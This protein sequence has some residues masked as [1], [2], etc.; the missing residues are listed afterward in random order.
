MSLPPYY[1]STFVSN[2]GWTF[3]ESTNP[4]DLANIASIPA[5]YI[6]INDQGNSV[7]FHNS[8]TSI[9]ESID[10]IQGFVPD[11]SRTYLCRI[12]MRKTQAATNGV[13]SWFRP[14]FVTYTDID[15]ATYNSA[16][17]GIISA[18]GADLGYIVVD[19]DGVNEN[20]VG[21]AS[22]VDTGEWVVG[23][24]YK[25][26]CAWT[27]AENI[28]YARPRLRVNR[29]G[30]DAPPYSDAAF[31]V[32]LFEVLP[33]IRM[34]DIQ[35]EFGGPIP[36][37]LGAYY[38]NVI[39]TA[40]TNYVFDVQSELDAAMN[41]EAGIY[42][43]DF[44]AGVRY[45]T[46]DIGYLASRGDLSGL[47]ADEIFV[48]NVPGIGNV[49][50][51]QGLLWGGIIQPKGWGSIGYFRIV[52]GQTY[53]ISMMKRVIQDDP[54]YN[55]AL[56]PYQNFHIWAMDTNHTGVF[57]QT[58]ADPQLS[59]VDGWQY[60]N[61][62][63]TANSILATAPTA[64]YGRL[65]TNDNYYH[66]NDGVA[67]VTV[68]TNTTVQTAYMS[69]TA[70]GPALSGGFTYDG[71]GITKIYNIIGG[72]DEVYTLSGNT[73]TLTGESISELGGPRQVTNPLTLEVL[74]LGN[75]LVID[76]EENRRIPLVG[77][78]QAIAF[79][80]F[81]GAVEGTPYW[82]TPSYLGAFDGNN[83]FYVQLVAN[84]PDNSPLTYSAHGM[85]G[86]WVF[87]NATLT[88]TGTTP[89]SQAN[90]NGSDFYVAVSDQ[91]VTTTGYFTYGILNYPPS[92]NTPA[93]SIGTY[94]GSTIGNIFQFSAT[95]PEHQPVAYSL[96]SGAFAPNQTL[97]ANGLLYSSNTTTSTGT[98]TFTVQA[99]DGLYT[100]NQAF[101]L[102]IS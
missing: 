89:Y 79:S 87:D 92:W 49:L 48:V 2:A 44:S 28:V 45:W 3:N 84:S 22:F 67:D 10:P 64:T 32:Q 81:L 70:T 38:R 17:N 68:T 102:T 94:S 39:N 83:P 34:S 99:S 96:V 90:N 4:T 31:E 91:Y 20:F 12:T 86:G 42:H 46:T 72:A 69:I 7:Y 37:N 13:E 77:S 21:E 52:P 25:M 43:S 65:Y 55:G 57:D 1:P 18:T 50:Q 14:G 73:W 97:A 98:Y 35:E 33:Q 63:V 58:Y 66:Q 27:P 16:N 78:G 95:D 85:P 74:R 23:Q 61:A 24:W 75:F 60:I 9:A 5:S 53:N 54:V 93:G 82:V 59:V 56:A 62:T 8:I 41:S 51:S 6:G 71:N 88:I 101:S 29:N 19:G 40:I 100:A 47:P 36:S 15:P 11:T 76:R 80:D 26:Y 30:L